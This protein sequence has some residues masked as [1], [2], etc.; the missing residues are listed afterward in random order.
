MR[1]TFQFA[2]RF[3]LL[4]ALANMAPIHAQERS[5]SVNVVI[6]QPAETNAKTPAVK[7]ADASNVVVWLTPLDPIDPFPADSSAREKPPRLVQHN[8]TFEPHVLVVRV[9]TMVEFPNRDPFFHNI[10]SLY[11]GKRFD[12]GLYEAGSTRSVLFNRPGVSFLFCNIHVEMS[13][14]IVAVD[15]PFFGLSDRAG[16]VNIT[17]L[18]NGRYQLNVWYERSL[19]AHLRGLTRVVTITKTS[20]SIG[21]IHVVENPN[22]TPAHKNLY[23][24]DYVPPVNPEYVP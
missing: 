22:F 11:D 3:L 16:N 19:P 13:A 23:G 17:D 9:G 2:S 7:V 6:T 21:P 20:R 8:K 18:P 4:L 15:T 12:L 10:F 5:A 14:V 24:L 1:R